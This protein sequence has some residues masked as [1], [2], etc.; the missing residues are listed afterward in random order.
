[1]PKRSYNLSDENYKTLQKL[2]TEIGADMSAIV[3]MSIATFAQRKEEMEV[4]KSIQNSMRSSEKTSNILY[5]AFNNFLLNFAANQTEYVQ[6]YVSEHA[7]L[8]QA[9]L[10]EESRM[11]MKAHKKK[12]AGGNSSPKPPDEKRRNGEPEGV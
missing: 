8:R 12:W 11:Q 5:A 9:A 1:M 2:A 6:P 3:N 10:D 4:L 7:W